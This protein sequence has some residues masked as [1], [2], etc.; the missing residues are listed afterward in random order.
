MSDLDPFAPFFPSRSSTTKKPKAINCCS[1]ER[2]RRNADDNLEANGESER[3]HK[4]AACPYREKVYS[5]RL[6]T[7]H[8]VIQ[9]V[10]NGVLNHVRLQYGEA[11]NSEGYVQQGESEGHRGTKIRRW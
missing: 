7:G 5:E 2:Y 6:Q 4:P 10:R 11:A 9:A 8:E 1:P 3:T